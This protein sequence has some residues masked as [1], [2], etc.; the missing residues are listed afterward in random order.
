MNLY[1]ILLS[2]L[3]KLITVIYYDINV[4]SRIPLEMDFTHQ[5]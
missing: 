4:V 1:N 5:M 2:L 3:M